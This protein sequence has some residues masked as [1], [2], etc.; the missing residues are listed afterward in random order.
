MAG[1]ARQIDS[2]LSRVYIA[3][4]TDIAKKIFIIGAGGHAKVVL[5]VAQAC[6]FKVTA[7][8]DDAPAKHGTQV[9][10]VPVTSDL[11]SLPDHAQAIAGIGLNATRHAVVARLP[12]STNWLTL[13]HPSAW[14][15]P[16][17]EI[18]AG[19]VIMAGSIVQPGTKIGAHSIINTGAIVDHDC[20]IGDFAHVAPGAHICGGVKIEEGAFVCVGVSIAPYLQIGAWSVIAAGAVVLQNIAPQVLAA[21]V[22]TKIKKKLTGCAKPSGS[23]TASKARGQTPL[24]HW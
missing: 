1:T 23:L 3:C 10:G 14:V 24:S 13:I 22:P 8:L 9:L 5:S 16:E 12:D 11:T 19:S 21:G 15:G 2:L 4:M 6:G 20:T 18:G 7:L 17:V